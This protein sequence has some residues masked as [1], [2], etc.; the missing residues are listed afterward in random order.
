MSTVDVTPE[1]QALGSGIFNAFKRLADE[2]CRLPRTTDLRSEHYIV[3]E[4]QRFRLWDHSLG[5][6]QKGHSFLDYRVRDA[7]VVRSHLAEILVELKEHLENRKFPA[8]A[9][10]A[11]HSLAKSCPSYG[12]PAETLK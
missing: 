3:A 6:H 11:V 4:E 12:V 8:G 10:N 5:L 7:V 9:P 1:L 2:L